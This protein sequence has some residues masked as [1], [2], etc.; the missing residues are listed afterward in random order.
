[1]GAIY[2]RQSAIDPRGVAGQGRGWWWRSH[3]VTLF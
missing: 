3:R 1:M 2:W